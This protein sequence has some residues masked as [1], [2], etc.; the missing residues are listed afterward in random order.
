MVL[1]KD[2]VIN[3][4]V[5]SPLGTKLHYH[6]PSRTSLINTINSLHRTLAS[7]EVLLYTIVVQVT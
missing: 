3:D 2:G 7:V 1:N 4:L 6:L 5:L